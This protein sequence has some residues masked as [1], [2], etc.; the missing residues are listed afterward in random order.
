MV[1]SRLKPASRAG[2]L[3]KGSQLASQIRCG[4]GRR[5]SGGKGR[6]LGA[7]GSGKM[8]LAIISDVQSNSIRKIGDGFDMDA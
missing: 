6:W 1:Q 5:S 3:W 4:I 7:A 8:L 2:L